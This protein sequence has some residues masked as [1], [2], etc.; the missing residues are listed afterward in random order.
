MAQNNLNQI[1]GQLCA[2]TFL[3]QKIKQQS[4]ICSKTLAREREEHN[5]YILLVMH[6]KNAEWWQIRPLGDKSIKLDGKEEM[7]LVNCT[8]FKSTFRLRNHKS[9]QLSGGERKTRVKTTII[10][11]LS[12]RKAFLH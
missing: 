7:R 5:E 9:Q 3:Q 1:L 12:V 4:T 10:I 8:G 11:Y 6:K 2:W